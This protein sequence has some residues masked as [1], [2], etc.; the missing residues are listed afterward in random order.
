[1]QQATVA[2]LGRQALTGIE[3]PIFM[4]ELITSVRDTLGVDYVQILELQPDERSL[5]LVAGV[6]WRDG[7]VGEAIVD[8]DDGSHAAHT[9][10]SHQPVII[11][12]LTN[13]TRFR[14]PQMLVDHQI[15]SGI[16][17]GIAGQE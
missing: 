9:L 5:K 6:G 17:L 10:I 7:F 12:D 1:R 3:L 13:E 11:E 2:E 14:T 8:V 4:H 15:V 16:S